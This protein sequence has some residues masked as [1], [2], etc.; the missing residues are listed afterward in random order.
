MVSSAVDVH[1]PENELIQFS[2]KT[3]EDTNTP[4]L[5][6]EGKRLLT[7]SL[8]FEKLKLGLLYH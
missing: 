2:E 7:Q 5:T 3:E 4:L 6:T 8:K 1:V